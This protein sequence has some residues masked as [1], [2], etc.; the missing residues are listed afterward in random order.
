M[1]V[2]PVQNY[3]LV[4]EVLMVFSLFSLLLSSLS[5]ILVVMGLHPW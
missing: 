5:L 4:S 3:V 2:R 1:R